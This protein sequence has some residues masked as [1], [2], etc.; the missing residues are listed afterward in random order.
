MTT[1]GYVERSFIKNNDKIYVLLKPPVVWSLQFISIANTFSWSNFK[2][3]KE[4]KRKKFFRF[5]NPT[6]YTSNFLVF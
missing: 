1:G 5:R 3:F 2:V 6:N 4:E